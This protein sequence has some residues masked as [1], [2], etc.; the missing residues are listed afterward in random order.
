LPRG[1]PKDGQ[2]R[3]LSSANRCAVCRHTERPRIEA[4]RCAGV[5]LDRISEQF[6]LHRDAIWRHMERHVSDE[7]KASYLVGAGKLAKLAEVAAEESEAV[8]DWLR[9]QRGM[10]FN[11]FERLANE[12]DHGGMAVMSAQLTA[13]LKE[14]AKVTGQVSMI[15]NST[16]INVQN[17]VA[18]L[19]SAPFADLQAGLLR[20]CAAHPDARR[21]II[22]LFRELDGKYSPAPAPMTISATAQEIAGV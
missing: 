5:S 8:I 20:V 14:V 15:A 3:R 1:Y 2:K 6:D 19:N 17:N 16:V 11:Q 7:R 4:L 12:G 9:V 22:A 10:L 13:V 21:D 18:V